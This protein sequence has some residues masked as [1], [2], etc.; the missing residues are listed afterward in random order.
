MTAEQVELATLIDHTLLRADVDRVAIERLC[1]EA[2]EHRFAAVCVNACWVEVAAGWLT[3]TDVT[4][5]STVG[6]PL[7]ATT[8]TTKA[9]ETRAVL[10]AGAREVDMVINLG[11]LKTGDWGWVR[12]DIEGVVRPCRDRGA[13]VK[14]IIETARLTNGEKCA[15]SALVV[16]AAAAYVKTSTGFGPGGATVEDVALIRAVVGT[17]VGVKAAGGIRDFVT[18][19]AMVAAGANRL[20]TSAGV[21]IARQAAGPPSARIG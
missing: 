11:A 1:D 9:A 13:L 5:C 14:V 21:R 12:R 16:E 4:V 3:G 19:R 17:D 2:V 8:S 18:A 20:G 7:G 10:D 15:A 6:F